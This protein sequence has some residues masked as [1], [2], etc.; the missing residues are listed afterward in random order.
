M[1]V[2]AFSAAERRHSLS[3]EPEGGTALSSGR[4]PHFRLAAD[5]RHFDDTTRYAGGEGNRHF[6]DQIVPVARENRTRADRDEDVKIPRLTAADSRLS[7]ARH[8]QP[9]TGIDSRFDVQLERFFHLDPSLAVTLATRFLDDLAGAAAARA[10]LADAEKSLGN[11]LLAGAAAARTALLAASRF[12]AGAGTIRTIDQPGHGDL[13]VGAV[14][15]VL[16]IDFEIVPEVGAVDRSVVGTPAVLASAAAEK[17]LERDA[18]AE[19]LAEDI[20]SVTEIRPVAAVTGAGVGLMAE[21]VVL[22]PFF[23]I[24]QHFIGERNFFEFLLGFLVPRI[25]VGVVFDCE[26]A[27]RFLQLLGRRGFGD[28][29]YLIIILCH[30]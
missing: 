10:G 15:G 3:S 22:P 8:P 7:L 12:T 14:R 25:L 2:A 24:A 29:E 21:L 19:E 6:T 27:V 11:C 30:G 23:R 26:L 18:A 16:K 28:A 20:L 13:L 4:N 1:E 5:G 9:R 17:I